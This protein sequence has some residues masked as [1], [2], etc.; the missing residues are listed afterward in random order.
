[1]FQCDIERSECFGFDSATPNALRKPRQRARRASSRARMSIAAQFAT[2]D[3]SAEILRI[4]PRTSGYLRRTTRYLRIDSPARARSLVLQ[5][6]HGVRNGLPSTCVAFVLAQSR[7]NPNAVFAGSVPYLLATSATCWPD[8]RKARALLIA[9][10]TPCR[11]RRT[12]SSCVPTNVVTARFYAD[13]H[14][15]S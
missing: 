10:Q 4:V 6:S 7:A 5:A 15:L 14:F 12:S 2:Y 8:G 1:M 13:H 9:E 11:R 3:M